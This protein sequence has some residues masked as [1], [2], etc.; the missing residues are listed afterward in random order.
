MW[1][2]RGPSMWQ[3]WQKAALQLQTC[4]V[5]VTGEPDLQPI[6]MLIAHSPVAL[7]AKHELLVTIDPNPLALLRP[8]SNTAQ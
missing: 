1:M 7:L 6:S 5:K 8:P 3:G 2:S 4:K